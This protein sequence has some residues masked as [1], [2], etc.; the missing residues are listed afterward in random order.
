[1]TKDLPKLSC[2]RV[3]GGDH[4][5]PAGFVHTPSSQR[6]GDGA[7]FVFAA[8][9][10]EAVAKVGPSARSVEWLGEALP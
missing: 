7:V 6:S 3:D 10:G 4:Q 9:A 1:V 5:Q 2:W 8:T